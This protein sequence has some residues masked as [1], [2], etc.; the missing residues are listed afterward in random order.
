MYQVR[1]KD[2]KWFEKEVEILRKLDG[3]GIVPIEESI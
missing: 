1:S 2:L 3:R